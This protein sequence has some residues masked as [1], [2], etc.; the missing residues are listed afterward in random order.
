MSGSPKY[1]FF[2]LVADVKQN[3]AEAR[4]RQVQQHAER[5]KAVVEQERSRRVEKRKRKLQERV[6]NLVRQLQEQRHQLQAGDLEAIQVRVQAVMTS[7]NQS[8]NDIQLHTVLQRLP[9]LERD[10]HE[11]LGKKQRAA[12]DQ[13]KTLDLQQQTFELHELRC[14][15]VNVPEELALKFDAA[16][17]IQVR[18]ALQAVAAA[19]DR[20][21][22]ARVQPKLNQ[23]EN[24]LRQ[25]IDTVV[26]QQVDWEQRQSTAE[27]QL[28]ELKA[29]VTEL[30][31]ASLIKDWYSESL[32]ALTTE[33][34]T[35]QQAIEQEQFHRVK[36]ILTLTQDRVNDLEER[37]MAAQT[38]AD[39]R[40]YVTDSIAQTLEDMGF[41][42]VYRKSEHPNHPASATILAASN[43]A[44]KSLSVSVPIE[45]EVFYDVD[46]YPKGTVI[47]VSGDQASVCDEAEQVIQEM[48]TALSEKRGVRMSPLNWSGKEPNHQPS[49]TRRLSNPEERYQQGG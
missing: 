47:T 20:G 48:H 39:Q 35:A 3:L 2:D 33:V 17:Q 43:N 45:G 31:Q 22:P 12:Q 36:E 10:L 32:L 4:H 38:K 41:T 26:Q 13:K 25:H 19:L 16:G 37:A 40:D 6:Q 1:S 24:L 21:D 7:V 46:G 5:R 11:A 9:P 42:I 23:A 49:R 18:Q 27:D 29:L 14:R 8:N 30:Q 44:G 28:S 34:N 15:L